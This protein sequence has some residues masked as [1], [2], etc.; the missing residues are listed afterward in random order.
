MGALSV[1]IGDKYG[2]L[3]VLERAKNDVRKRP[4]FLCRCICG[5]KLPVRSN[6]LRTGN[7]RSCGC[8]KSE[9]SHANVK[10][11]WQRPRGYAALTAL[12]AKYRY[13][14]LKRKY[15][16]Q[17]SLGEFKSLIKKCCHFCGANPSQTTDYKTN[18][19]IVYNGIDC[20]DP[21]RGYVS[22]NNVSCCVLCNRM[23]GKRSAEDFI[24]WAGRIVG[25]RI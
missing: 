8:L 24:H 17:L 21:L 7:T 3:T 10:R 18:G 4:V 12:Y 1:K 23:K 19:N 14:A 11:H 20:L 9:S 22:E 6:A 25:H 16:F 5:T 2:R 13:D 15:P